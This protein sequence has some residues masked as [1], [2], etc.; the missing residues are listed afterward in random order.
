MGEG[1]VTQ[2]PTDIFGDTFLHYGEIL[3]NGMSA[4]REEVL[5]DWPQLLGILHTA[6]RACVASIGSIL[7]RPDREL[8]NEDVQQKLRRAT[9]HG[10]VIQGIHA[11]EYCISIGAYAQAAALVRQELEAVEGLRGIRQ[12]HQKNGHTPRIKALKHVGGYYGQLTGLAHLSEH[13]LLSHVVSEKIGNIVHTLN[14]EFARCLFGL[15]VLALVGVTLDIA[16]LRP[17]S[18]SEYFSEDEKWWLDAACGVLVE[19]GLMVVA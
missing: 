3:F 13:K 10:A 14:A 9:I 19:A 7:S 4:G 17:F 5:K 18:E 12:G 16:E 6:R 1:W 8:Q 11:V 15:H 2:S